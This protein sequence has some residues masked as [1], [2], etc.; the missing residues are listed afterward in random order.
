MNSKDIDFKRLPIY[1]IHVKGNNERNILIS[2]QINLL[3]SNNT[4]IIA[5]ITPENIS[6]YS[7][8][9]KYRTF[10]DIP[11]ISARSVC[12]TLSHRHVHQIAQ[13]NKQDYFL[14]LE[15]DFKILNALDKWK[16]KVVIKE[17]CFDIMPMGGYYGWYSDSAW[18][19]KTDDEEVYI[20]KQLTCSVA[21]L[22][23]RNGS[24]KFIEI[25]DSQYCKEH[26]ACDGFQANLV[27]SKVITKSLFPL[28]IST[29]ATTSTITHTYADHESIYNEYFKTHSH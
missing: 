19:N 26:F 11:G 24:D 13:E 14:V 9:E 27:F 22:Y 2:S 5:A 21:T 20:V 25:F 10:F 29:Y 1:I 12:C 4:L 8:F 7:V 15:D 23:T 17:F 28:P 16:Q 6:K 18:C 3:G